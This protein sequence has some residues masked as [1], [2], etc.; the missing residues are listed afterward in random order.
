MEQQ[1]ISLVNM[2]VKIEEALWLISHE[3]CELL[4][5]KGKEHVNSN[6]EVAISNEGV[7]LA[8]K[9]LH[10]DKR[11]LNG[12]SIINTNVDDGVVI[13]IWKFCVRYINAMGLSIAWIKYCEW[14]KLDRN[15][16]K[17]MYLFEHIYVEVSRRYDG[18]GSYKHSIV[19]ENIKSRKKGEV[20][21]YNDLMFD[22]GI[23]SNKL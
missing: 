23:D 4:I 13:R 16:F 12:E 2:E 21:T 11:K 5:T 9:L 17:L 7:K 15:D 3:F 22:L 20:Y 18:F 14:N 19:A 1:N 8:K 6:Y 10:L